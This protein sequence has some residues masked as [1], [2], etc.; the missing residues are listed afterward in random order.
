MRGFETTSVMLAHL[1]DSKI[2]GL[3]VLRDNRIPQIPDVPTMIESGVEGRLGL[4]VDRHRSR[5]AGTPNRTIDRAACGRE[6]V[7]GVHSPEVSDRA[8]DA[9]RSDAQ[10]HD[11]TAEFAS[12]VA[13]ANTSASALD[14]ARTSK[15]KV[16]Q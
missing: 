16:G 1:H 15:V 10:A 12:F 5:P 11:A 4:V 9:R 8:Q 2:R 14:H 7:A 3:A 6:V 13:S